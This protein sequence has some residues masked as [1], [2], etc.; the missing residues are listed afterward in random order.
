MTR[1]CS[2]E[3][4]N[5]FERAGRSE[6]VRKLLLGLDVIIRENA[7][8]LI[9]DDEAIATWLERCTRDDRAR[10]YLLSRCKPSRTE[11]TR[12]LLIAAVRERKAIGE[13]FGDDD[14]RIR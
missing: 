4:V 11:Q 13:Q 12:T 1:G 3:P 7:P 5:Q 8:H 14:D 6:K 10:I 2:D 9:G